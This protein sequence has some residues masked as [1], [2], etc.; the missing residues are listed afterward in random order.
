MIPRSMLREILVRSFFIQSCWNT[1]RMQN[2]GFAFALLPLLQFMEGDGERRKA[3]LTRHIGRFQSN[4]CLSAPIL[5]SVVSME[6]RKPS[7]PPENGAAVRLKEVLMGPYAALGDP[8]F[9]GAWK[10]FSMVVGVFLAMNGYVWGG[11]FSLLVYN[12]VHGWIRCIGFFEGYRDGRGGAGFLRKLKLPRWTV[13]IKWAAV[14][15]VSLY[16]GGLFPV[17]F[18]PG[19]PVLQGWMFLPALGFLAVA[20]Y[21]IRERVSLPCVIYGTALAASG[22]AC[23]L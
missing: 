14:A 19:E 12:A 2:V 23:L 5:G 9:W 13:R 10:P 8:F 4:P 3:F 7:L 11:V 15:V 17:I 21:V 6:E 22:L 18:S 1:D 20:Y 16:G